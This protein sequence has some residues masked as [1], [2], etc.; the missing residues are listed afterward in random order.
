MKKI[1]YTIGLMLGAMTLGQ[2]QTKLLE[3]S[4]EM[5]GV[6]LVGADMLLVTKKEAGGQYLYT[7]RRGEPEAATRALGL[8]A[9][10]INAVIG[11][12]LAAGEV[13]VYHKSGRKAEKISVYKWTNG[14]FVKGEE[15]PVPRLRNH[16][17]NLGL[18]LTEDQRQ[19][20]I[21]AELAGSEGYDDLYR[22]EW[23][24]KAWSKPQH[25]GKQ[26]NTKGAEFAPFV[27]GDSLFFSRQEGETTYIY[28]APLQSGQPGEAVRLEGAVNEQAAYNAYYRKSGDQT[29]WV[30]G[31]AQAQP[32]YIAY[33][34]G[35]LPAVAISAPLAEGISKPLVEEE[36]PQQV[37]RMEENERAEIASAGP[38]ETAPK[39]AA[40]PS[41]VLFNEFNR[42]HLSLQELAGLSR[43]LRQQP[44]GASFV[45]KGYS[46]GYGEPAAKQR[47]SEQRARSV[48][49]YIQR[50]F[51]DK[52]FQVEV[53]SEVLPGKGKAY[54]KTELYLLQ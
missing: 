15:L 18:F 33:L 12:N 32:R 26:V 28:G 22:S 29:T 24:G 19:L 4:D 43:F 14:E 23:N 52:D 50:Y 54:R 51:A 13:F 9:G 21:A 39:R 36:M 3:T 47:V 44:D 48:K 34:L 11:G 17:Y 37:E 38:V 46:D 35:E 2:A 53:E 40:S 30:S 25:L 49:N 1:V 45:I 8:N 16:S 5:A 41:L 31:T 10:Q 20:F 27:S 7:A 6:A 42:V